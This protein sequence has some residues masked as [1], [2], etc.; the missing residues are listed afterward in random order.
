MSM[1]LGTFGLHKEGQK[2]TH[3]HIENQLKMIKI[4]YYFKPTPKKFRVIGDVLMVF[5]AG[6]TGSGMYFENHFLQFAV[7]I[8][9]A[10]KIITNF[11]TNEI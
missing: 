7:F 5:S 8:G 10:G 6:V 11:T 9:I 4:K 1:C 3:I 2:G